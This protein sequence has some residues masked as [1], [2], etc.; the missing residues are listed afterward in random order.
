[1]K[2]KMIGLNEYFVTQNIKLIKNL[3]IK[4]NIHSI[5]VVKH[6]FL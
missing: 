2:W 1:M 5:F 3:K 6:F 4:K